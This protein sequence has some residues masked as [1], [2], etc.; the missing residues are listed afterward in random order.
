M[1]TERPAETSETGLEGRGGGKTTT[2]ET[3]DGVS[4]ARAIEERLAG[5]VAGSGGD[6][7]RLEAGMVEVLEGVL[8]DTIPSHV[9]RRLGRVFAGVMS[10]LSWQAALDKVGTIWAAVSC[11]SSRNPAYS[12]LLAALK[13]NGRDAILQRLEG[14]AVAKAIEGWEEPVYQGGKLV[15]T[16]L[17]RSDRLHEKLLDAHDPARY[18]PQPTATAG[19]QAGAGGP[20]AIQINIQQGQA[21]TPAVVTVEQA[22]NPG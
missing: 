10:G 6:L 15:G 4:V 1:T 19:G 18:N 5:V 14:A 11:Y 21:Q 9:R 8:P 20:I 3:T 12:A 22:D 17:R 7:E 16:I 2:P 13:A